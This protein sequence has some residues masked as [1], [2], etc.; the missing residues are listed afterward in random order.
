[1]HWRHAEA[2]PALRFAVHVL[3]ACI[4]QLFQRGASCLCCQAASTTRVAA[5]HGA[6]HSV[7]GRRTRQHAGEAFLNL[8]GWCWARIKQLALI[9]SSSS[10]HSE[11][12]KA[13]GGSDGVVHSTISLAAICMRAVANGYLLLLTSCIVYRK[14]WC[15]FASRQYDAVSPKIKK[16]KI[17]LHAKFHM[18][19]ENFKA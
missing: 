4:I 11:A 12:C 17:E 3:S 1:M 2:A 19:G 8:P 6:P 13:L 14:A 5:L 15:S 9:G 7:R 18:A 10:L 16:L